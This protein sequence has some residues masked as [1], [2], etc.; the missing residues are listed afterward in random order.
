MLGGD[1][2]RST[3]VFSPRALTRDQQDV[4]GAA[5]RL[6]AAP[7]GLSG[8]GQLQ[9]ERKQEGQEEREAGVLPLVS[10]AAPRGITAVLL[11]Y[12]Y[13]I[14]ALLQ[15]YYCITTVLLLHYY[16]ITTV[17]LQYYYCITT[18]LLQYYYCITTALLQYYYCIT[19]ALLQ[20]YYSIT[21]ALLQDY[22]CITA[23]IQQIHQST[24][25]EASVKQPI[26]Q[27]AATHHYTLNA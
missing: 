23:V 10:P 6:S 12:Y 4:C 24:T 25:T 21:T 9:G 1:G 8:A 7:P 17:L 16:S 15:Y 14:T 22:Y 11:Q 5:V 20:Y 3:C 18:A 19:T 27:S 26:Q 13:C 2:N